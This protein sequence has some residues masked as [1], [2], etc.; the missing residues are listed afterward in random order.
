VAEILSVIE[1]SSLPII[2][3]RTIAQ[4][5]LGIHHARLLEK[6]APNLPAG[7]FSWGHQSVR[8]AQFCG[9]IQLGDLTLEILPKIHG[10]EEQP[11]SCRAAMVQMLHTARIMRTYKGAQAGINT[12]Q[13]SLLDIF[14]QH[15][16]H[17]LHTQ[18]LQ[19]K[20]RNYIEQEE[21]LSVMRGRLVIPQHIRQNLVHKERLYCRFDE[22]SEDMLLNQILRFTLRLLLPW[23]RSGKTKKQLSGLLMHFDDISDAPITLQSFNLLKSDRITQRFQ[24]VLEQCRLFIAAVKP[25]VL[26]GSTPLFSLLFDMNR[27]FEAWVAEKLKP[28]A[29]QQGWY[30]RTQGPRKYLAMRDGDSPQFQ[31]RP[32]IALVDDNGVPQLIADTKWKLLNEADR[33]LGV[34]SSDMY[35]LY[36]YAG[37]YK[38]P[39]LQLIYPKQAGLLPHYN[40]TLQGI[41]AP[42]LTVRTIAIDD[43]KRWNGDDI[44]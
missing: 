18:I 15:F 10:K 3:E 34:S 24:P 42:M 13:H 11:E 36:A 1:H 7:T 27:L 25:D 41:H 44:N 37:R 22:F 20:L 14:I 39:H 8:F 2:A 9:V 17:D 29:H 31:L 32:D 23:T 30:L 33:K 4:H 28:W 21:N 40:F 35:Q 38:A 16:C 6:L 19:G 43:I 12:Q 5:A 26:A